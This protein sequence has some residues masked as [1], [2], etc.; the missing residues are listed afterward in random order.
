MSLRMVISSHKLCSLDAPLFYSL[1]YVS[2]E[3]SSL[4]HVEPEIYALPFFMCP[5]YLEWKVVGYA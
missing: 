4:M 5:I 1:G 2:R 3:E